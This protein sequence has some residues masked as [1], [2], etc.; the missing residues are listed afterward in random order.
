MKRIRMVLA[1]LVCLGMV[2]MSASAVAG[3]DM[4][5]SADSASSS[6]GNSSGSSSGGGY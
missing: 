6:S 3:S 5:R 4:N 2:A 1:Y